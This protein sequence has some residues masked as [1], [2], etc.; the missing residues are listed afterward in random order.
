[1]Q[2]KTQID[3]LLQEKMDRK[4]FLKYAGTVALGVIG[5]TGLVRMLLGGRGLIGPEVD[6]G[7][8]QGRGY[9]SSSYGQ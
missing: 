2:I 3:A 9:G 5:I 4:D 6:N 7:K 8:S 1:M